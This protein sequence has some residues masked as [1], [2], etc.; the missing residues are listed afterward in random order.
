MNN[1]MVA[2][3]FSLIIGI[4]LVLL[5]MLAIS[6]I[7]LLR[8]G[9]LGIPLIIWGVITGIKNYFISFKKNMIDSNK[10]NRFV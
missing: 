6:V 2:I 9:V 3:T 1:L 8:V 7:T 5:L 4:P 10:K